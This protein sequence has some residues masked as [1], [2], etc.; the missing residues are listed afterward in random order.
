MVTRQAFDEAAEEAKHSQRT[1]GTKSSPRH[2]RRH[3]SSGKPASRK[4]SSQASP[5]TTNSP[6]SHH[7]TSIRSPLAVQSVIKGTHSERQSFWK[8]GG[9]NKA[10]HSKQ[11]T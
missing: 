8:G 2:R 9:E 10:K 6:V 5:A 1:K 11:H 3:A 7:A 4:I